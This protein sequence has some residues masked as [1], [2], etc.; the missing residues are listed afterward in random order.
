MFSLYHNT[1]YKRYAHHNKSHVIIALIIT[2]NR[3]IVEVKVKNLVSMGK[4]IKY[5]KIIWLKV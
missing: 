5:G 4:V 1:R 3:F 2:A